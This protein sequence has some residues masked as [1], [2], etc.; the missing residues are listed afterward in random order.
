[1]KKSAFRP[2]KGHEMGALTWLISPIKLRLRPLF[3]ANTADD[4]SQT[5]YFV[6]SAPPGQKHSVAIQ[7]F[8]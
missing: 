7:L 8:V 5:N 6:W 4:Q 1:M 3:N 2:A